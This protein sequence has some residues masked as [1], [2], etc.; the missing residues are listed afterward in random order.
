[1]SGTDRHLVLA[2]DGH[3]T[4]CVWLTDGPEDPRPVWQGSSLDMGDVLW[5]MLVATLPVAAHEDDTPWRV[6]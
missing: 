3:G 6:C 4:W 5:G 2:R 1:M